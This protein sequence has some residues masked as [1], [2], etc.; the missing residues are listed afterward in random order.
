MR[1]P[2]LLLYGILSLIAAGLV[3]YSQTW[4]FSWDE[5]F[6]LLA[7]QL[8]KGG[9]QP[10]VD[11]LFAQAP[12]NVYL[13]ALWMRLFGETWQVPHAASALFSAGAM[14]L[15]A[16][17]VWRRF[18]PAG[19]RFAAAVT[20][21]LSVGL[22]VA[23]VQF[24][25]VGQAY[26]AALL[27][28][29]AG[30]RMA[31][32]RG[33]WWT[34]FGAGLFSGGAA[35]C[36]L[37]TAPAAPILLIWIVGPQRAWKKAAPFLAGVLLAFVPLIRLF[38][39]APRQTLFNVVQYHMIYR[40]VN[41]Y[42]ATAHNIGVLTAWLNSAQALLLILLAAYGLTRQWDAERRADLRLCAWLAGI[43]ALHL[44][45]ARPTFE[46]YFL[47]TVPFL[48]IL[49]AAAIHTAGPRLALTYAVLISLGLA[50]VLYDGRDDFRWSDFEP[51]ARKV[52]AVAPPGSPILADEHV[53]FLMKRQ[54]PS[55][56]ECDDSHKLTFP[57]RESALFHVVPRAEVNQGIKSGA[58]SAVEMC[59][60]DDTIEELGMRQVYAHNAV[61][62]DCE[63]FWRP[64]SPTAG[65]WPIRR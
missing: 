6:H 15:T 17:Y 59:D 27:L 25:T 4:A 35:A 65:S 1:K 18:S 9:K 21:G 24:G 64:A 11:F 51:V 28:L 46:Q 13:N 16:D 41:W 12:L 60:S 62:G 38:V 23:V 8:V 58:F 3:A 54:P 49:A 34:A 14:F 53:Y 31:V 26:G 47:L 44:S 33:G 48:S 36:T 63:V 56:M 30:F 61:F 5:G 29:V 10:Y 55:G 22:N 45:T 42:S 32:R 40:A 2:Y 57:A 20:A 50:K 39:E 7:A 43:L 52:A 19:W 37:L